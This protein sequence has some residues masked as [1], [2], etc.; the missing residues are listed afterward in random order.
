V[1]TVSLVGLLLPAVSFANKVAGNFVYGIGSNLSLSG[2]KTGERNR[3]VILQVWKSA[4]ARQMKAANPNLKVLAI[5]NLSAMVK[6]P[7]TNGLIESGVSFAQANNGHPDFFLKSKSGARL[8]EGSYNWMYMADIANPGYQQMWAD[9]V[10]RMLK[11][12]PW[13]GVFADDTNTTARYHTDPG[14]IAKYPNDG[15]YQAA[16]RSMLAAVSPR[17][18]GAGYKFY[19]NIGSWV[20]YPSVAKDWL[21]F[22]DGGMDEMFGKYSTQPGVG[23]RDPFQWRTQVGEIASTEAMGKSF[24]AVTQAVKS[25]TQAARFGWASALLA[26]RGHTSFYANQDSQSETWIPEY[27]VDLGLPVS[28]LTPAG[29]GAF[30]RTFTRGLV[31]ANPT[32]HSVPVSFGGSY[33]GSGLANAAGAT[34]A[35]HTGLVLHTRGVA[36]APSKFFARIEGETF[37]TPR[38]S[39]AALVQDPQAS[40]QQ[41]ILFRSRHGAT[42]RRVRTRHVS[43]IVVRAKGSPCARRALMRVKVGGR[44]VLFRRILSDA[45]RNYAVRV[46]LRSGLHRVR[47]SASGAKGG[48]GAAVTVD[49]IT[50]VSRVKG[51][52]AAVPSALKVQPPAIAR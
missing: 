35:P 26:A 13:D 23:Y 46:S 52:R 43:S 6:A 42:T 18:H 41:G 44:S 17:L 49:K 12:G 29:G 33:S 2:T 30:K 51:S 47:L 48:C 28:G 10:I 40:Q 24:L 3:V 20:S 7:L 21:Q 45:Y 38:H 15:S 50:F 36:H 32:T 9:N 22:L 5:M 8:I 37:P 19:A 4:L 16:T 27:N 11:T 1:F 25:D 31:L 34:M 14:N 39:G